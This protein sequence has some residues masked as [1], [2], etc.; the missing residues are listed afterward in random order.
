M[1]NNFLLP[2]LNEKVDKDSLNNLLPLFEVLNHG[3][4]RCTIVVRKHKIVQAIIEKSYASQQE[5]K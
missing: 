1:D 3:F 2:K 5:D 4:G